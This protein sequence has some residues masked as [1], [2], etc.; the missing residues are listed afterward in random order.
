MVKKKYMDANRR[1]WDRLTPVHAA[2]EFYD[3]D[4]FKKGLC[5]LMDI[6]RREVGPV[7]DRTLLHL[8]CHFGLDTLSWARR[9]ARVTGVDFSERAIALAGSIA[10]ELGIAAE[11]HHC[12]IYEL[13][14]RLDRRFDIVYTAAGVLPWLPDLRRWAKVV[15][16]FLKPDGF[17]FLRE[18]HP[19]A[20]IFDDAEDVKAPV[21]RYP[22]F[23]SS[24]PMRFQDEG[25][26]ADRT[27]E[28][29]M[30][31]YEWAHSLADVINALIEAGLVIQYLH[32]F[33]FATYQSLPFLEKGEDGLWRY[34]SLPDSLPLT[35]SLRAVKA[36]P[37]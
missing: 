21:V 6:D 28:I 31:S 27:A 30:V 23:H 32:E 19:T 34:P 17:F 20:F 5:A 37:G 3:L 26:Y 7:A 2:S 10:A 13:P 8:Q 35:Y 36:P 14:D 4:G 25:S 11:F 22:Y 33:P 12:N 18:D 9:G 15:A 29:N 1:L 16:G 24:E